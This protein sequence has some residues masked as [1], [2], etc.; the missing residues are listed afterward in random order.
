LNSLPQ[1]RFARSSRQEMPASSISERNRSRVHSKWTDRYSQ[2]LVPLYACEPDGQTPADSINDS[3]VGSRVAWLT[4]QQARHAKE[5]PQRNV[6]SMSQSRAE[7]A[8]KFGCAYFW[9]WRARHQ[10]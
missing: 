9:S 1:E 7:L 6:E 2:C 5:C 4:S 10:L 8:A 3:S